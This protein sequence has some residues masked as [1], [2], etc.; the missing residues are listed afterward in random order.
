M[1]LFSDAIKGEA[2]GKLVAFGDSL[3]A[4][5]KY[6]CLQDYSDSRGAMDM[7]LLPD[8]GAWLSRRAGRWHEHGSDAGGQL[9]VL[10]VVRANPLENTALASERFCRGAGSLPHGD[11]RARRRGAA[12]GQRV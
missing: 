12:G 3:G 5:V 4:A 9:D 7:G 6:V 10:S 8:L 11:R 2:V 1:I